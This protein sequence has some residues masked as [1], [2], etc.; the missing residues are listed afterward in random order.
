MQDID[1]LFFPHPS[2]LI[3]REREIDAAIAALNATPFESRVLYLYGE[4]GVGKTSL[5]HTIR[6]LARKKDVAG[7]P[8][9]CAHMIDL[10]DV[11][12]NQAIIFMI[13]LRDQLLHVGVAAQHFSGFDEALRVYRNV[14]GVDSNAE[15]EHFQQIEGVFLECY[16]AV[17]AAQRVLI[18]IDTFERLDIAISEIERFNFRASR[19]L[20]LWLAQIASRLP[21]TIIIIAGR[22]RA[23]QLRLLQEILGDKLI[24]LEIGSLSADQSALFVKQATPELTDWS[25]V[26][27]RAS[28][29]RP[30]VLLIAIACVRAGMLDPNELI[31]E[32]DGYPDN[33]AR[34]TVALLK[35]I[36]DEIAVRHPEWSYLLTR[37]LYLRKGL[38]IDLLRHLAAGENPHDLAGIEHAYTS[39][40]QLPIIKWIGDRV[41]TLHDELYD[42]LFGKLGQLKDA[43]TWYEA[44]IAYLDAQLASP[45][46]TGETVDLYRTSLRQGLQAERL[47]YRMCIDTD[48]LAGYQDYRE[49]TVSAIRNHAHDFDA[50]LRSEMARFYDDHTAW[51]AYY[52]NQIARSGL[53]WERMIYEEQ[54]RWVYRCTFTH[55]EGENR[56]LR[57]LQTVDAIRRDYAA[58]IAGDPLARCDLV[59][60]ELQVKLYH[61]D[62]DSRAEEIQQEYA[63]VVAEMERL[64]AQEAQAEDTDRLA[65]SRSKHLTLLLSLAYAG[66]GYHAR[67][68][69]HLPAAIARYKRALTYQ[70][71][72]G[73]EI[74][75]DRGLT[76]NNCGNALALQGE[77]ERGMAY[78]DGALRI[79][80]QMNARHSVG[81]SLNTRARIL[82]QLNLAHEALEAVTDARV[83]FLDMSSRRNLALAAQNEGQVRRWLAYSQRRER[84]RSEAEYERA[85]IRYEEALSLF[86]GLGSGE[87][88]R[89]IEFLQSTGCAHRSRGFARLQ[90]KE[91]WHDEMDHARRYL[92]Q[93]LDLCPSDRYNQWPIIP[94]LLEDIAVTYVNEDNYAEALRYL[95]LARAAVP[96]IYRIDDGIG[97]NDTLETR[98]QK[99]YWLRLG[100]IELQYALCRFGQRKLPSWGARMVRACACLLAYSPRAP[101]IQALRY[102]ARREMRAIGDVDILEIQRQ[103]A[104]WSARRLNLTGEPFTEIDQLFKE[105]IEDIEL[106]IPADDLL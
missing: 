80:R 76:L 51:G 88:T 105:V 62:Y 57:A 79:Y 96:T 35:L 83:I 66:W 106:G 30:I 71:D 77:I 89:K 28:S 81:V 49:I 19:R 104:Y 10:Q 56:Y 100:Q 53:S 65:A 11:R 67:V 2:A 14:V 84:E 55:I 29:G 58:I 101:Q 52:R 73:S 22:P 16:R 34:L 87:L 38:D 31:T 37:A 36:V 98:E 18:E 90:R 61:P 13:A 82:L 50:M 68:W 46:L 92:Q 94:A 8:F 43:C 23:A 21:N 103:E 5:L 69:Q 64:L 93:A 54:V 85:F 44:T 33:S 27:H 42:L 63:Q 25:D 15:S 24:A 47:F 32:G 6:D 45:D 3:G 7:C 95:D 72:L 78:V 12:F 91:P 41:I 97:I 74:D 9:L 102:L 60:A 4:G 39:F 1:S 26:L 20:D 70:N 75:M 99:I 40:V 86:E 48:P 59:V 17:A